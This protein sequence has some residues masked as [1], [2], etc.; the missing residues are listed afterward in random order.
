MAGLVP[1]IHVLPQGWKDVDARD[2]RGHD[3]NCDKE[4]EMS[5]RPVPR[6]TFITLGVADMRV[7]IAFY[8]RL[9]FARKFCATG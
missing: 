6:F 8:E 3:E 2:E 1:A 9:G 4:C 7:S 5:D